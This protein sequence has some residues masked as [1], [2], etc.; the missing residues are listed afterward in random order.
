M[1]QSNKHYHRSKNNI[2]FHIISSNMIPT[3]LLFVCLFSYLVFL[4]ISDVESFQQEKGQNLLKNISAVA[5]YPIISGN[6]K[7]LKNILATS[8]DEQVSHIDIYD[9]NGNL[10]ANYTSKEKLKNEVS[11]FNGTIFRKKIS[12]DNSLISTEKLEINQQQ[13]ELIASISL[14]LSN[15]ALNKERYTILAG[16]IGIGLIFLCISLITAIY[17]GF[18]LSYPI[19]KLSETVTNIAK[20]DLSSRS[21][22]NSFGE[23]NVLQEGVNHMASSLEKIKLSL[24]SNMSNLEKSQQD[25]EKA[26]LAK[27]EFLANISH[28]LRTP[29]NGT[30]GIL[31]LLRKTPLNDE[32]RK[33]VDIA[34]DSNQHFLSLIDNILDFS[35]LENNKFNSVKLPFILGKTLRFCCES[36]QTVAQKNNLTFKMD[37]DP[38]LERDHIFSDEPRI[39]QIILNIVSNAIKFTHS[40]SITVT[41]YTLE[42]T[43][44][45]D[46]IYVEIKDTGIGI[47]DSELE[48]I[49]S[50]FH[51]ADR[52][53]DKHFQ[54][55]GLGLAIVKDLCK[56][57]DI[58]ISVD[59]RLG[60][61]TKFELCIN[62]KLLPAS[63]NN[64]RNDQDID[65][66]EALQEKHV[67]LV[68]D[69]EVNKLIIEKMLQQ[70]KLNVTAV[71][72]G[73][74]AIKHLQEYPCDIVLMDCQMP[75]M[76]G[77]EATRRIRTS[78]GTN[79]KIPIV[80]ISANTKSEHS[81]KCLEAG[82]N[83][84]LA[85]PFNISELQQTISNLL[86]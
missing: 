75:D 76:D 62:S 72:S 49:F 39:R 22:T 69:N 31:D 28:E 12:L 61:G 80:A 23:I 59:S 8:V 57:L 7:L 78:S 79:T 55:A 64:S 19:V 82:M 56:L 10:I 60:I 35:L 43:P 51:Q 33:Y 42:D 52:A 3:V 47:D 26:N 32:Q 40:G 63:D 54:G 2:V 20:G 16:G 11:I 5:E 34:R 71:N 67:L 48:N 38:R 74:E 4:R 84:Y 73:S 9:T 50:A 77:L 46:K 58:D 45:S 81:N 36:L 17:I 44:E 66:L 29:M 13:G 83:C 1:M 68:D 15:D 41:A 86:T 65:L 70:L 25:A 53:L 24:D 18:K 30:T 85:K 37:I 6:K 14:G 21:E 27:S